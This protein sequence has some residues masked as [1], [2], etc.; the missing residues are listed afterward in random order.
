MVERTS[1]REKL[2]ESGLVLVNAHIHY[3]GTEYPGHILS[4][5]KKTI[6]SFW[7][8]RCKG[9]ITSFLEMEPEFNQLSTEQVYA[10]LDYVTATDIETPPN[11]YIRIFP[12]ELNTDYRSII[13]SYDPPT[14]NFLNTLGS[15][16]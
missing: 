8:A 6:A 2:E 10:A 3:D 12:G 14:T 11:I 4:I 16:E 9:K 1:P 13:D 7:K 5:D 15:H